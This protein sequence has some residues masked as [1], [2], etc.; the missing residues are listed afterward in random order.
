M[1]KKKP[2]SI[3]GLVVQLVQWCHN[4][5]L[6]D[7]E[8]HPFLFLVQKATKVMVL[9]RGTFIT[10]IELFTS[11]CEQ[12]DHHK[13][14][15]ITIFEMTVQPEHSLVCNCTIHSMCIILKGRIFF[16]F[17]FWFSFFFVL[18]R[19]ICGRVGAIEGGLTLFSL[20]FLP[21]RP[22]RVTM[23]QKMT[24]QGETT[25]RQ[26]FNSNSL[27]GG[28]LT[29][30]IFFGNAAEFVK[31]LGLRSIAYI[32]IHRKLECLAALCRLFLAGIT[33][34]KWQNWFH[35]QKGSLPRSLRIKG[36]LTLVG[37]GGYPKFK[38]S[39]SFKSL[40]STKNFD[41]QTFLMTKMAAKGWPRPGPYFS[42]HYDPLNCISQGWQ[43][44]ALFVYFKYVCNF[45][46]TQNLPKTHDGPLAAILVNI[47]Q[48]LN[49]FH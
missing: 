43:C 42:L 2:L 19:G 44:V 6:H 22:H 20:L 24:S 25:I 9:Q 40:R 37:E 45:M 23:V 5:S 47:L 49:M 46:W 14:R 29:K 18:C 26:I 1:E 4:S 16:W 7:Q 27:C 3:T 11:S 36:L 13:G 30:F 33:K 32:T 48:D 10:E 41:L 12:C 21:T 15:R 17:A 39:E 8:R 35:C 34:V 38:S 28:G 31:K